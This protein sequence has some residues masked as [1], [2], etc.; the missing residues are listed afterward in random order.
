MTRLQPCRKRV[1]GVTWNMLRCCNIEQATLSHRSLIDH[2]RK[3]FAFGDGIV[4]SLVALQNLFCG[5]YIVAAAL[6]DVGRRPC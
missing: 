2:H 4:S 6:D 3:R 5:T 1:D